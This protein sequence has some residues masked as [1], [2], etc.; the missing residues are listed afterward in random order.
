[1]KVS[2]RVAALAVLLTS[3]SVS[4]Q[5]V[6]FTDRTVFNAAVT[7]GQT[8]DFSGLIPAG[9]ATTLGS[10]AYASGL[11][12]NG[13]TFS[14]VNSPLFVINP[15]SSFQ[16]NKG[17][18]SGLFL[19]AAG[20]TG[21][22]NPLSQIL[23]A[24]PSS[25]TAFGFDLGTFS[26]RGEALDITFGGTTFSTGTSAGL[27][28]PTFIGFTSNAPVTSILVSAQAG[29]RGDVNLD[30]FTFGSAIAAVPEPATW[31]LMILGFGAIGGSMRRRS[32]MNL[33]YR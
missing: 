19:T 3:A 32:V 31:A 28:V 17:L 4:A 18:G 25:V 6:T 1:M 33:S 7:G 10:Q 21:A 29:A 13:A 12:V 27:G 2:L 14:G 22:S 16:T 23:I 30:T 9:V 20:G 5:T 26:P 8:L 24:L 11:T 15:A